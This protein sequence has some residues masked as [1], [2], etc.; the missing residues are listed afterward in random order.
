MFKTEPRHCAC[1]EKDPISVFASLNIPSRIERSCFITFPKYKWGTR[2]SSQTANW[3]NFAL[4]SPHPAEYIPSIIVIL[5]A[6]AKLS[7]T[8]S[9]KKVSRNSDMTAETGNAYISGTM[10]ASKFESQIRG[11]DHVEREESIFW[12]LRQQ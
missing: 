11:F 1:G 8:A 12:R 2:C 6:K 4:M 5:A 3:R 9:S 7:T 10:T